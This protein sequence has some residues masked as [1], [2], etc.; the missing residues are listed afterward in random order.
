MMQRY[1]TVA[2]SLMRIVAGFLFVCHGAQKVFGALHGRAS[3]TPRAADIS[4]S[5]GGPTI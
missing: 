1:S 4:A 5:S 2:Y 3:I